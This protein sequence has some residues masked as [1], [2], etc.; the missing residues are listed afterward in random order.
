MNDPTHSDR[1][2]SDSESPAEST[3]PAPRPEK[4][5]RIVKRVDPFSPWQTLVED[6]RVELRLS[7]RALAEKLSTPRHKFEHT[8]LWAWCHHPD[9]T[10]PAEAYTD[11]MNANL[12]RA[13]SLNPQSLAQAYEES[14]R[15]LVASSIHASQA[16]PLAVLRMLF[17]ESR[18]KTFTPAEVV[19]LIDK[20][21]GI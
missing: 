14:R 19:D 18:R 7:T 5:K 11:D 16:G 13:L 2:S 9:G 4:P 1:N 20:I 21:R 17:A 8:T 6:R 12:A 3:P 10:P 15:R